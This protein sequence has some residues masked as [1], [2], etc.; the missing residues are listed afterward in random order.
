MGVHWKSSGRGRHPGSGE[1][2]HALASVHI[3]SYMDMQPGLEGSWYKA[4]LQTFFSALSL[5][6][7]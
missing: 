5:L 2:G 7:P 3:G 4:S 6:L 1:L